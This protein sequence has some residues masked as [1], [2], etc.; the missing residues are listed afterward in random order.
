[1]NKRLLVKCISYLII[2]ILFILFI[3]LLELNKTL[4]M[5]RDIL[6]FAFIIS[7]LFM[8]ADLISNINIFNKQPINRNLFFIKLSLYIIVMSSIISIIL[9]NQP[10]DIFNG[11]ITFYTVLIISN[12]LLLLLDLLLSYSLLSIMGISKIMVIVNNVLRILYAIFLLLMGLLV[13]GLLAEAAPGAYFYF[14]TS[15]SL[16]YYIMSFSYLT[17]SIMSIIVE[18]KIIIERKTNR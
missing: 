10:I 4:P 2:L 7:Y 18:R 17:L 8:A 9:M 11:I 3:R 6:F 15:D 14:L 1:M 5:L 12:L 13:N 16:S